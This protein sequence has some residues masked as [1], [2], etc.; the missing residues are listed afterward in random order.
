MTQNTFEFICVLIII[1][2]AVV[3][4]CIMGTHTAYAGGDDT[5]VI[6]WKNT[7]VYHAREMSKIVTSVRRNIQGWTPLG[8]QETKHLETIMA[9]LNKSLPQER[10]L[11]LSQMMSLRS[12][13]ATDNNM[14]VDSAVLKRAANVGDVERACR[15][16]NV[17]PLM[18]LRTMLRDKGFDPRGIS[19]MLARPTLEWKRQV[20]YAS[21]HDS[22]NAEKYVRAL[23][24]SL[25]FE[26]E[27]EKYLRHKG[28]QFKTQEQLV[29][30]QTAS[31][32]SPYC[33]PDFLLEKPY[34][35]QVE[36]DGKMTSRKIYW[37][38]AKNYMLAD[39]GFIVGSVRRQA[40]KY[41]SLIGPGA[42]LFS[43]GFARGIHVKDV[44]LLDWQGR[45]VI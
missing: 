4:Y 19:D 25:E 6:T 15:K 32:G 44:V 37:I 29:V 1:V 39:V 43:G 10:Q 21:S 34:V 40:E 36:Q 13:L 45:N 26:A 23:K 16:Y 20:E 2:G 24:N 12:L 38:D 27:V 11:T 28:I 30:D 17:P 31:H 35:V 41:N 18:V 3:M 7:R 5:P 42:F 8:P 9:H 14:R 33:T 22:E